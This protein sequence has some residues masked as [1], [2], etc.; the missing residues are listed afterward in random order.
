MMIVLLVI[1]NHLILTLTRN[2]SNLV[3]LI[4]IIL[5]WKQNLNQ[6]TH[7]LNTYKVLEI[8]AENS[9]SKIKD[10]MDRKR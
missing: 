9:D 5:F 3:Q 2:L 10:K 4:K 1:N 7:V 6:K 8:Q